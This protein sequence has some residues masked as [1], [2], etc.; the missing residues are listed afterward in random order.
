M[1]LSV[2]ELQAESK[3]KI[4][5]A[6]YGSLSSF[7][8]PLLVV[9]ISISAALF[10]RAQD[11]AARQN[12]R[13]IAAAQ[14]AAETK[15]KC[16]DELRDTAGMLTNNAGARAAAYDAAII[17]VA[18]GLNSV[19]GP[20]GVGLPAPLLASLKSV[21]ADA[22]AAPATR[23][24]AKEVIA[25]AAA[26]RSAASPRVF[27]HIGAEDQRPA[28]RTLELKLEALRVAGSPI[29][30]PGIEK[31][32]NVPRQSE[33]RY[34]NAADAEQ[35]QQLAALLGALGVFVQV[36]RIEATNVAPHSFEV[37]LKRDWP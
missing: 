34:A 2:P 14:Q 29:I 7:L 5:N 22:E 13:D 8:I 37:W 17:A 25:E 36:K 1:T 30:V 20:V 23:T 24:A 15:R 16:L 3:A 11:K 33:L 19:C 28:A 12:D 10:Q 31:V 18:E 9:L 27:F 26:L 32:A 4:F 6:Y 21:S 35:A